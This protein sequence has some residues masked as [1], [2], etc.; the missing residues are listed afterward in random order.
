MKFYLLKKKRFD[1]QADRKNYI[2]ERP[3]LVRISL[4]MLMERRP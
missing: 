4:C 1:K 3:E 2:N